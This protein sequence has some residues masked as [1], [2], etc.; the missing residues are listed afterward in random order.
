MKVRLHG[1]RA[2]EP[3]PIRGRDGEEEYWCLSIWLSVPL[4]KYQ[5]ILTQM[6]SS[7]DTSFKRDVI[8]CHCST[9]AVKMLNAISSVGWKIIIS[10]QERNEDYNQSENSLRQW[11]TFGHS[12]VG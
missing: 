6:K 9:K 12:Q 8:V 4:A 7:K 2:L 11:S 3:K 5:I 1:R 10:C